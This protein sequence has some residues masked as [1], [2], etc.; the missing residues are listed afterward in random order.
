MLLE[1]RPTLFWRQRKLDLNNLKKKKGKAFSFSRLRCIY[2]IKRLMSRPT[3]RPTAKSSR[4]KKIREIEFPPLR[5]STIKVS[6]PAIKVSSSF[7]IRYRLLRLDSE[8]VKSGINDA[9]ERT[10]IRANRVR[11]YASEY[12][13]KAKT[14]AEMNGRVR[15]VLCHVNSE[16]AFAPFNG[17]KVRFL[18]SLLL[19]VFDVFTNANRIE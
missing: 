4:G 11:N 8:M 2:A 9:C 7:E 14:G 6:L 12:K 5:T 16:F 17:L 13:S 15:W 1:T 18:H 19:L 10:P 3:D